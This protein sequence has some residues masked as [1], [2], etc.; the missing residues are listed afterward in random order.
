MCL[1]YMLNF[2]V[3]PGFLILFTHFVSI[4]SLLTVVFLI[5]FCPFFV[6]ICV[7]LCFSNSS[8]ICI[9]HPTIDFSDIFVGFQWFL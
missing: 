8:L 2:L 5:G 3:Y 7:L 9:H 1:L 6:D 4:S